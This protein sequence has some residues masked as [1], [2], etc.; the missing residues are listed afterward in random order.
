MAAATQALPAPCPVC[1]RTESVRRF[2][3]RDPHYGNEGW[4]WQRECSGCR[5]L[6][7]DPMPSPSDLPG[8]YP[9]DDYYAYRPASA[10]SRLKQVVMTALGCAPATREPTFA[11]PGRLL[12]FGCGAGDFLAEA[13]DRGWVGCGVEVSER[14]IAA[15]KARGLEIRRSIGECP[16]A[17]YDYV[18]ANHSLEHV[19]D[20][21]SVLEEM[22]RVLKPG[23]TLFIGVPTRDGLP[24]RIFG[25]HWWYLGAPVHPVTF[26]TAALTDL[27]RATGFRPVRVSTNS[28]YG[29]I[30]GSLQ[31]FLNRHNNRTSSDGF[32]FR[33]KPAL[34]VGHWAARLLD[35]VGMGDKLE[36]V[37]LKPEA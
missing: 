37:A 27:L 25:R 31:I 1:G 33:F 28:D 4:W 3:A 34:L 9:A 23:G 7:L 16:D 22:Y 5:S 10:R 29:S 15:A 2:R 18:R 26:S 35:A 30:A 19:L 8:F 20:P 11:R 36:I 32:L 21:R 12:D 17:T 24:A 6:F 14:A 13:R